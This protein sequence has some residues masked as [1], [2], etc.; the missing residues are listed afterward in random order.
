MGGGEGTNKSY[1]LSGARVGLRPLAWADKRQVSGST[2]PICFQASELQVIPG[3]SCDGLGA[4]CKSQCRL[5]TVDAKMQATAFGEGEVDLGKQLLAEW[6]L[7]RTPLHLTRTVFRAKG[8]EA[9]VEAL[10]SLASRK[11]VMLRRIDD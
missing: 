3:N 10:T 5:R 11:A 4:E 7:P 8:F 6:Q 1:G 9:R 2:G